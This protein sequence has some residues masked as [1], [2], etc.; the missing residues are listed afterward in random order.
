MHDDQQDLENAA[1]TLPEGWH[2]IT[3]GLPW[4]LVRQ[5]DAPGL[6]SWAGDPRYPSIADLRRLFRLTPAQARVT[7]MLLTRRTNAEM[8]TLLGVSI[9]T[10]RRHVE[11]VLLRLGVRSRWDVE[12]VVYEAAVHQQAGR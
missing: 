2:H 6:Y 4:A 11:A 10:V 1:A 3:T 9:H 5:A 8:V 12:R 7:Q